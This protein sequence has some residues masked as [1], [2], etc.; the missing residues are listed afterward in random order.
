MAYYIFQ[1]C[2]SVGIPSCLQQCLHFC[3]LFQY[4][5]SIFIDF[6]WIHF[7]IG[8]QLPCFLLANKVVDAVKIRVRNISSKAVLNRASKIRTLGFANWQRMYFF[9]KII[10]KYR[11]WSSLCMFW[12]TLRILSNPVHFCFGEWKQEIPW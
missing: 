12:R 4:L 7:P 11:R 3:R 1:F 6:W 5:H 9:N 10:Y 8:K 2:L